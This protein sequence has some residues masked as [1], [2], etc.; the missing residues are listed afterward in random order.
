MKTNKELVE[1][2]ESAMRELL[3]RHDQEIE[4]M[5]RAHGNH[6]MAHIRECWRAL[7]G[8]MDVVDPLKLAKLHA[9]MS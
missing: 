2:A 9:A 5:A 6:A 7:D 3:H 1:A 4:G 8:H